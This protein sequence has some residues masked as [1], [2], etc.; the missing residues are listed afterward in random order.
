MNKL[1]LILLFA[2]VSASADAQFKGLKN[3]GKR[4]VQEVI[5]P[6]STIRYEKEVKTVERHEMYGMTKDEEDMLRSMNDAK[7]EG[8]LMMKARGI[9]SESNEARVAGMDTV[10]IYADSLGVMIPMKPIMKN[11]SDGRNGKIMRTDLRIRFEA[12]TANTRFSGG[13][14]HIRMY[15]STK[16]ENLSEIYRY[17]TSEHIVVNDMCLM[18]MEIKNGHRLVH[19]PG[20]GE[21]EQTKK[22]TVNVQDAGNGIYDIYFEGEPGEYC[23]AVKKKAEDGPWIDAKEGWGDIEDYVFDFGVDE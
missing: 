13:K 4:I 12:S 5:D 1:T 22:L 11:G 2:L 18:D 17:F 10:G 16:K 7:R 8:Y 20:N 14:G 6:G 15:F 19:I 9:E 3:L 21:A 23:F